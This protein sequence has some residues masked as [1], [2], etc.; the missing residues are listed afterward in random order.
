VPLLLD[1]LHAKVGLSGEHKQVAPL[2]LAMLCK[3]ELPWHPIA[4]S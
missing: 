2:R 3:K 4:D 1:N